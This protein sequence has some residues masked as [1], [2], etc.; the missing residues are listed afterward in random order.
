MNK[1][2]SSLVLYLNDKLG[3]DY[4]IKVGK[5]YTESIE[6]LGSGRTQISYQ[7]P[8]TY[9]EGK[10]KYGT[11]LIGY[12]AKDG[13]PTYRSAIVVS[14]NSGIKSI[15]ELRGKRFAFGSEKSTGSTLVPMAMLAEAGITLK[16]LS[17]YA[18]LGAHDIVANAVLKG[19]F[20]AGGMMESVVAEFADKGIIA[21]KVSEPIPQFP[22]CVNKDLEPELAEKLKEA[23]L[24]ISD[25][26]VIR[27]IDKGYTKFLEAKDSDFDGVRAMVK[28][29]YNVEYK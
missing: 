21:L 22:I 16:D 24:S 29:L 19:E 3:M 8:T 23:L 18:Y 11:R 7:T 1:K 2:F 17:H 26:S 12:F 5:D 9:I 25:S 15:S 10:H 13:S 20:D 28:R 4:I 27:T 6:D 14:K